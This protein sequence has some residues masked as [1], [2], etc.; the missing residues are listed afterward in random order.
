M[1]VASFADL[2]GSRCLANH[3]TTPAVRAALR[4][5]WVKFASGDQR[6]SVQCTYRLRNPLWLE[7]ARSSRAASQSLPQSFVPEVRAGQACNG[8]QPLLAH[9][10]REMEPR[11]RMGVDRTADASATQADTLARRVRKT[12]LYF[13]SCHTNRTRPFR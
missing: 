3:A 12:S 7:G 6:H 4:P 1:R 11:E 10:R 9:Q 5:E 8:L 13:A 2:H